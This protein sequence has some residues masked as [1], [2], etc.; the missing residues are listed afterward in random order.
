M[1]AHQSTQ[2]SDGMKKKEERERE[3]KAKRDKK[4]GKKCLRVENMW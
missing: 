3:K 4:M 2:T 1:G